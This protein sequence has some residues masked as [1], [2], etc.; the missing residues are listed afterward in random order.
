MRSILLRRTIRKTLTAL[1]H[2][3]G[4]ARGLVVQRALAMRGCHAIM[5]MLKQTPRAYAS[6][7]RQP[8]VSCYGHKVEH[9]QLAN[10]LRSA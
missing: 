6:D 9:D 5:L 10:S 8:G 1:A 4:L 2:A 3:R 7:R